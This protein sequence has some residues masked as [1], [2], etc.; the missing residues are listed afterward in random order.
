[1][2]KPNRITFED[3]ICII[4]AHKLRAQE[5]INEL[6]QAETEEAAEQ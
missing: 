6:K 1:M 3:L 5:S 2:L 4:E